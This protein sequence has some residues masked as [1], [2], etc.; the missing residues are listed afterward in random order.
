MESG[1]EEKQRAGGR[2]QFAGKKNRRQEAG[3]S[4]QEKQ[5]K[6]QAKRKQQQVE[7]WKGK[8][9][10]WET[11]KTAKASRF[12]DLDRFHLFMKLFFNRFPG[13]RDGPYLKWSIKPS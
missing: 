4:L 12:R 10:T 6:K 11:L 7:K 2:W 1:K 13:L 3:G 5:E 8:T 9:K